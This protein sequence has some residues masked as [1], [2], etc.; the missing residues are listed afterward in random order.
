MATT[1]IN[2]LAAV[3][4][5]LGWSYSKLIAE[6]RRHAAVDGMVLPKNESLIPLVSRWVNNHQQPDDFH[7]ELLSRATGR[8]RFELF[9]D[10]AAVLLQVG[11]E[12]AG[13]ARGIAVGSD[14]DMNRRQLLARAA[15]L[16]AA[17]AADPLLSASGMTPQAG[18]VLLQ[19][20]SVRAGVAEGEIVAA[21]RQV[22]LGYGSPLVAPMNVEPDIRELDRRV[23]QAWKL[24]QGSHYM[25]L[26]KVLPQ[27]LADTQ[28]A[29][30]E[31][32][33]DQRAVAL[34]LLAHSYSTASSV[35]RKLGDNGLAVIAA[36]RAVQVSR[37]V[38]EPLL[39]AASAYR[40]ANVFLPAGRVVE[41]KEV[42][43]FAPTAWN[44]TSTPRRRTLRPGADCC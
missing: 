8:P 33:G 42:A 40:L 26:G 1:S 15:A 37:A 38:G 12:G 20:R 4:K 16:G 43:M 31:L 3:L 2:C 44:P 17:L 34:G 29:S 9:S 7:R 30:H 39:V 11:R 24:R 18:D 19:P 25:E 10:E 5:E 6:L 13:I 35:L 14:E 36:D 28:V 41:A 22:L 23:Y 21:I 27:L 32:A